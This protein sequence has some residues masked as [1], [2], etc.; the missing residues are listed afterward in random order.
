MVVDP[1]CLP[2]LGCSL[3]TFYIK[4]EGQ[5]DTL[6]S[7]WDFDHGPPALLLAL[8]QPNAKLLINW[9]EFFNRRRGS[10][11]FSSPPSYAAVLLITEVITF[12]YFNPRYL[13][14]SYLC[15]E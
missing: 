4:G 5:N 9:K 12:S 14:P 11:S 2:A 13:V 7:F 15:M 10:V 8:T 3:S 6:H 1:D